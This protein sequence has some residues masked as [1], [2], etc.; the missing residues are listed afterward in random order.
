MAYR[1]IVTRRFLK[2]FK[3]L[4]RNIQRKTI[5]ILKEIAKDPYK[6]AEKVLAKETGGWRRRLGDYRIRYDISN[7][8]IILFRVLHRKEIYK[9]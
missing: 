3:K 7:K 2:D 4:P 8:K 9:K 1:I 5:K 6:G